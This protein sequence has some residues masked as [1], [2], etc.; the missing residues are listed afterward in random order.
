[1]FGEG[2]EKRDVLSMQTTSGGETEGTVF[3]QH[4]GKRGRGKFLLVLWNAPSLLGEEG[5]RRRRGKERKGRS[6][7]SM[8]GAQE[9]VTKHRREEKTLKKTLEQHQPSKIR[10]GARG[11]DREERDLRRGQRSGKETV[12]STKKES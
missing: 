6:V 4:C 11:G 7:G 5:G 1:L 3:P 2:V 12:K 9:S 10:S 8:Q